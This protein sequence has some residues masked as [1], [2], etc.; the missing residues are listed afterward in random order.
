MTVEPVTSSEIRRSLDLTAE[1]LPVESIQISSAVEGPIGFLPWR[2][3]DCV[4]AGQKFV[5]ISLE[6]YRGE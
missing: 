3:G 2:E 6:M 1:V 5:E 4:E